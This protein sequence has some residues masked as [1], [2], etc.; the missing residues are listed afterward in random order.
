[1]GATAGVNSHKEESAGSS[2]APG[3]VTDTDNRGAHGAGAES[4]EPDAGPSRPAPQPG[5]PALAFTTQLPSHLSPEGSH[6]HRPTRWPAPA[7]Q[8]LTIS[9][10]KKEKHFFFFQEVQNAEEPQGCRADVSVLRGLCPLLSHPSAHVGASQAG[11][12]RPSF[13]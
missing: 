13:P 1:M 10:V 9:F 3:S 11:C 5:L 6:G 7:T 2:R 12:L 4:T 8:C